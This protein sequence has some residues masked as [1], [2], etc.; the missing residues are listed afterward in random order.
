MPI[1]T[2]GMSN[3]VKAS[4]QVPRWVGEIQNNALN[5]D[6]RQNP[7][8]NG[9]NPP[10]VPSAHR[11]SGMDDTGNGPKAPEWPMRQK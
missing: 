2:K 9:S 8:H 11:R 6:L 10:T 3:K 7:S 1:T 4:A 5:A